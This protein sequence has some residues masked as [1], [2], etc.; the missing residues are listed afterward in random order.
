LYK[1]LATGE[2]MKTF[3]LAFYAKTAAGSEVL[4]FTIDLSGAIIR[5]IVQVKQNCD[6]TPDLMKFA[7][8][9]QVSFGYAPMQWTWYDGTNRISY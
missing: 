4:Q 6:S 3:N 5:D 8:Y 1:A 7:K 2:L 9:E